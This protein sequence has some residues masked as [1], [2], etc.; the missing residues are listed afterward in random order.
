[1]ATVSIKV[2]L[3][4]ECTCCGCAVATGAYGGATI[5]SR[6]QQC[7]VSWALQGYLAHAKTPTPNKTPLGP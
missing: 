6:T 2:F 4:L 7:M 5:G 3:K 1:M